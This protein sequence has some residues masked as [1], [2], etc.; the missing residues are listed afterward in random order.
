V[1]K[2]ATESLLGFKNEKE[3]I[4]ELGEEKYLNFM[5]EKIALALNYQHNIRVFRANFHFVKT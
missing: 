3:L 2:L 4:E 5:S 1:L